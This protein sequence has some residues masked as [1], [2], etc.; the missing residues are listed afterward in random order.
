MQSE[1]GTSEEKRTG[2]EL[3]ICKEFIEQHQGQIGVNR[4]KGVGA[5][6]SFSNS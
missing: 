4:K 1:R 5:E 6:F 2:L 3:V